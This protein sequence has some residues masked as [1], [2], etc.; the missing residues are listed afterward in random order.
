MNSSDT[1]TCPE[2][3]QGAIGNAH[4]IF[5]E[6]YCYHTYILSPPSP[7]NAKQREKDEYMAEKIVKPLESNGFKCYYGSRDIYGGEHVISALSKPITIIPTTIIPVYRDRIFSA[8]RNLLLRVDYLDRI[9]FLTFDS[10]PIMPP[11]VAKNSYS[12]AINDPYLLP[13][14]MKTITKKAQQIPIHVRKRKFELSDPEST[15]SSM[16][17]PFRRSDTSRISFR[18]KHLPVATVFEG[19]AAFAEIPRLDGNLLL[20][21]TNITASPHDLLSFCHSSNVIMRQG[22]AK[23]LART[24]REDIA[25]FSNNA[26]LEEFENQI[27]H[28]RQK[29][30][31]MELEQLYFWISAAIFYRIYKYHDSNL[32]MKMKMLTLSKCK[33]SK[34]RCEQICQETYHKLTASL[35]AKMKIWPNKLDN[36]DQYVKKFDNC[37]SMIDPKLSEKVATPPVALTKILSNLPW[38]IKHIFIV[39]ICEKLFQKKYTDSSVLLFS[40]ICD[41][42]GKKHWTMFID[43]IERVTE[44]MLGTYTKEPLLA[45]LKILRNIVTWN[46]RRRR[47]KDDKLNFVVKQIISKLVYHPVDKVRNDVVSLVFGD[48]SNPVDISQLGSCYIKVS[49]DL[50]ESCIRE[51]LLYSFPALT[52]HDQVPIDSPHILM[53]EAKTPESDSLLYVFR[54]R[55]LNDILNT[56]STDAAY[57][58]FQEMLTAI[59]ICQGQ[60]NIVALRNAPSNGVLPFCVVEHGKSLLS[61]LHEKENQLSWIQMIDILIDIT[62][63]IHHCHKNNVILREIT[64][65]SFVILPRGNGSLQT[66]LASFQYAKCL[67]NEE[68]NNEVVEYIDDI[69]FL[70][71]QGDRTEV[72]AAYFSPPETLR[73]KTFSKYSE[74]WM[75]AAT[76][77]SI[78]LYG[79]SPFQELAHLSVIQFVKEIIAGHNASIPSFLP[80]DLSEILS[81]NLNVTVKERMMTE[82]I[83][84]KLEMCK[85]KLG[86]R[87]DTVPAEKTVCCYINSEDILRGYIDEEQFVTEQNEDPKE[88]ICKDNVELVNDQLIETVTMKM[89]LNTRRI[90]QQ[91]N[92]ENILTVNEIKSKHYKTIL[93]SK[94]CDGYKCQLSKVSSDTG[95][96]QLFS[97]FEQI[98]LALFR[99]HNHNI[100]HCDLRCDHIYINQEKGTVKVSHFAR[101]MSLEGRQTYAFKMMPR[102]A[103]KWSPPEVRA[104]QMYSKASDI[105]SLAVVFWEAISIQNNEIYANHPLEPFH[106]CKVYMEAYAEVNIH[107]WNDGINKMLKCMQK[108][109]HPNPTKRPTLNM[110]MEV[111]KQI[112]GKS[113][114]NRSSTQEHKLEEEYGIEETSLEDVYDT[115]IENA[116]SDFSIHYFWSKIVNQFETSRGIESNTTAFIESKETCNYEDVGLSTTKAIRRSAPINLL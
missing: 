26:N 27:R 19:S 10:T 40:Q 9:V 14:L 2:C 91:L 68:P 87:Q 48:I 79:K 3:G 56:N 53:F 32:K 42:I 62:K 86:T 30:N 80:Q 38:D 11:A 104:N 112:R 111:I 71:V 64:P 61:F 69:N 39:A 107:N 94:L 74:A 45:C 96:D 82:T 65:A 101:A 50:V 29:Q 23:N 88:E 49:E 89:S 109:W 105:F 116:V 113:E 90:L 12:I 43:V 4:L 33:A 58:S 70:C 76:F 66:K 17:F 106:Q 22:A 21:S 73:D 15:V 85:N 25:N 72:I 78:L 16:S 59:K 5:H 24:I 81:T 77:L 44:Y 63:A 57:Q 115:V 93:I 110:I 46:L 99:L 84:N 114:Q 18:I 103:E 35:H 92:H 7:Q 67:F 37:L 47:R 28:L 98:T 41:F 13:K 31:T 75:L 83:L 1:E 55:T 36:N 102:G 8:F 100:V 95:I 52:V 54:Q 34:N 20:Q 6:L 97:Y 60:D 51:H 108:C